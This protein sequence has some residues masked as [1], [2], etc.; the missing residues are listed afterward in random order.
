MPGDAGR[1]GSIARTLT[2]YR[3]K[4]TAALRVEPPLLM[5]VTVA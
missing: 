4:A 5:A 1:N 2:A 3:V